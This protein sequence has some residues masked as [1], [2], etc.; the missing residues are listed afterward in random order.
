MPQ[1]AS[2]CVIFNP[3]NCVQP[4]DFKITVQIRNLWLVYRSRKEIQK[5]FTRPSTR[6]WK[7]R[8]L[9]NWKYWGLVLHA[10]EG[11]RTPGSRSCPTSSPTEAPELAQDSQQ[12]HVGKRNVIKHFLPFEQSVPKGKYLMHAWFLQQYLWDSETKSHAN[13]NFWNNSINW[14]YGYFPLSE[15]ISS[16]F[17]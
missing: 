6:G 11:A 17:C 9:W 15:F 1:S 14:T 4:E 5:L 2:W 3:L 7:N 16:S 12:L 13:S 8:F 10:A